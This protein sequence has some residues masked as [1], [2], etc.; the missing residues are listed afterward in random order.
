M[1]EI[2]ELALP[3]GNERWS[4]FLYNGR[5]WLSCRMK[6]L[7]PRFGLCLF[8]VAA[9]FANAG[10]PSMNVTVSDS[11]GKAA[12]KG[13]TKADGSFAT[14]NLLPGN[15]VVQFT[16]KNSSVKGQY[17]IVVAAGKKKVVAD[18]VAGEKFLGGGV[19]MRVEVGAGLN[20]IGQVWV[21]ST[22]S[23]SATQRDSLERTRDRGQDSHQAGFRSSL[24]N[25]QDKM[26]RR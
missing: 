22:V 14:A 13:A 4:S 6:N 26:T 20:I 16:A 1:G 12:F 23:S 18:A 2:E 5:A 3:G 11:T 19:A 24:S 7:F 17:S 21:G 8:L 10:V 25:T 15:Y 9:S